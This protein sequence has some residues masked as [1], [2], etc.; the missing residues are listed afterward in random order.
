MQHTILPDTSELRY[1]A[2]DL[3]KIYYNPKNPEITRL[4]P[5]ISW[6]ENHLD[7]IP[8]ASE[9]NTDISGDYDPRH[10]THWL[11][12]MYE[13]YQISGDL[14]MAK[15]VKTAIES[16]D[17]T[18]RK[19]LKILRENWDFYCTFPTMNRCIEYCILCS[20]KFPDTPE[21][22]KEFVTIVKSIS[23]S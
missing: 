2:A 13:S 11:S 8:F 22:R 1:I 23:Q 21:D 12:G 17:I 18:P 6:I 10:P 15:A 14:D 3:S 19:V 7:G 20:K 16:S 5:F 4:V 9:W